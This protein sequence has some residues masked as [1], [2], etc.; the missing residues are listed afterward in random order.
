MHH[1]HFLRAEL[2]TTAV[3]TT[4]LPTI[5]GPYPTTNLPP[6]PT[7]HFAL[8]VCEALRRPVCEWQGM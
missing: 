7:T 6:P 4:I 1:H 8:N 2:T 5:D 3:M